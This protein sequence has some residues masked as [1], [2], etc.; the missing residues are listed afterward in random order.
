[1][2]RDGTHVNDCRNGFSLDITVAKRPR[3]Q[4]QISTTLCSFLEGQVML[5]TV[6][7]SVGFLELSCRISCECQ[8]PTVI[9]SIKRKKNGGGEVGWV[10][11]NL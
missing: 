2:M 6:F 4:L 11:S 3:Q 10:K 8:R 7:P 1:M 5:E 9:E